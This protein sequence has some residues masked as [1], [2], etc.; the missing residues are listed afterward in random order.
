MITFYGV[1]GN[2]FVDQNE[3]LRLL[4]EKVKDENF[5]ETAS[6]LIG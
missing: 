6:A 3:F 5:V 1:V 4:N 2:R